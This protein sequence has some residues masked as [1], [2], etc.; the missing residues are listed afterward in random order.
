MLRRAAMTCVQYSSATSCQIVRPERTARHAARRAAPIAGSR[1]PAARPSRRG[2]AADRGGGPDPP[3]G[4]DLLPSAVDPRRRHPAGAAAFPAASLDQEH[5]EHGEQDQGDGCQPD[6]HVDR[7]RGGLG[8]ILLLL[9]RRSSRRAEG[10]AARPAEAAA[11][12]PGA[13]ACPPPRAAVR[14]VRRHRRAQDR[15]APQPMSSKATST[16]A[17]TSSPVIS[18]V[19]SLP[20]GTSETHHHAG[21]DVD[22]PGQRRDRRG[23][24][25]LVADAPQGCASRVS[26]SKPTSSSIAISRL[27]P[28]PEARPPGHRG[29]ARRTHP[30]S[31][32]GRGAGTPRGRSRN[33]R[34]TRP[35][36]A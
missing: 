4:R 14:W 25:L 22:R 17:V 7:P 9:G 1:H 2:S 29:R 34:P 35:P 13:A 6:P 36:P 18:T 24:L 23:E 21:G 31:R 30:P 20:S 8:R 33:P 15:S 3:S 19:P 10:S 11:G 26:S 32:P 27:V 5:R 28:C 12:P 16:Q